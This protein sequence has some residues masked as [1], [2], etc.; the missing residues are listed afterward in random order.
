MKPIRYNPDSW[1]ARLYAHRYRWRRRFLP[2]RKPKKVF[3]SFAAGPHFDSQYIARDARRLNLF[4]EIK[5]YGAEDLGGR[6]W[7]RHG[8]FIADNRRGYG[9]WIWKPFLIQRELAALRDDDILV[10][11]DAG[12]IIRPGEE[13]HAA[14]VQSFQ[15]VQKVPAGICASAINF[16]HKWCK[17][18][19]FVALGVTQ[20]KDK[21]NN[22]YEGGRIIC[23]KNPTS[24]RLVN[25]WAALAWGR[26][27]HLFD[28]S[29]SRLPNHK[30]F[31]EH[32]HDQAIFS[33]L[34]HRYGGQFYRGMHTIFLRCS[35][36][37]AVWGEFLLRGEDPPAWQKNPNH[38]PEKMRA[39]FRRWAVAHRQ[40][41][42]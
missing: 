3:I 35:Y 21:Q 6:F 1:R 14:M 39:L 17:E 30:D 24:M 8:A 22:Q 13:A 28:N 20:D 2:R 12:A 42:A 29:P 38:P 37:M 9:F 33:I 7:A 5:A 40:A 18:D 16:S 32:R 19:A 34:M 10:Y 26:H 11:S 27:Y 4:D 31:R 23:R 15:H 25:Y 41:A 36:L